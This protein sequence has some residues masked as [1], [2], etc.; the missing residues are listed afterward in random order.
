MTKQLTKEGFEKLKKELEELKGQ[1]VEIANR[2][3]K[4]ISYGDLSEN[5][6]YHQAKEDQSFLE[7]RIVDL[8]EILRNAVIIEKM[9]GD[10]G[11]VQIGTKVTVQRTKP[12]ADGTETYFIVGAA[13]ANMAEGKVSLES[14]LGKALMGKRK[15][16]VAEFNAPKG[17]IEYEIKKID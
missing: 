14:P 12:K 4:A 16:D 8:E 13:E 6:D 17:K 3:K 7:G 5:A 15:G 2:L 11:S 10:K 1:R 9:E